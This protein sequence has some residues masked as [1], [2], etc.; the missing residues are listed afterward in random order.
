MACF[1][2]VGN[3]AETRAQRDVLTVGVVL[4]IAIKVENCPTVSSW[5]R[6]NRK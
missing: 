4:E 3:E 1:D 5:S 6:V 2:G